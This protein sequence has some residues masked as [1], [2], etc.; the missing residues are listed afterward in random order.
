V[1]YF[2]SN[3]DCADI[4]KGL[5]PKPQIKV[6]PDFSEFDL[7]IFDLTGRQRSA[8]ASLEGCPTIG[9]GSLNC[10]LEDDR[11]F[12]IELMEAAGI[13]VPPYERFQ[14]AASGMAYVK[15]TGKRYVFK[16]DGGQEQDAETTYVSSDPVDMLAYMERLEPKNTTGYILQEFIPGTE[17]SIEGWF[18]GQEFF[19]LNATLEDKKFMNDNKGPNTGCSGNLVLLVGDSCKLFKYGLAK[20]ADV[21]QQL[22]YKGMIDLNTIV[23]EDKAYGLEWTPRFG[24][25]ASATLCQMYAGDYGEMMAAV[26]SGA[27]PDAL[28]N[29]EYGTSVRLS[30]PPYPSEIK[31]KYKAGVI[32][33]GL[34]LD[35]MYA[36]DLMTKASSNAKDKTLETAGLSGFIAAPIIC[37]NDPVKAWE[38]LYHIVDH[39]IHIPNIQYRTDC[40]KSSLRKLAKLK[41][42]GWV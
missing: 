36:Y 33:E 39:N 3:P 19:L 1:S 11:A 23:T 34:D 27:R 35:T 18:N 7:S 4:L 28:W 21:L 10:K 26:T 22:G 20:A 8:D 32:C 37:G 12:G 30:I 42:Q 29:S 16:P 40:D 15:K 13:S 41:T 5:S 17:M 31:G 2:L 25:D 6:K 24:Y 38:H 9:D 14:D